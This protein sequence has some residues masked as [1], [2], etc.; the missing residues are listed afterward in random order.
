MLEDEE[1]REKEG[2]QM[3]I[4]SLA[5]EK[6]KQQLAGYHSFQDNTVDKPLLT[7]DTVE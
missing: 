4:I 3:E 2:R 5:T 1:T 7:P 6:Y